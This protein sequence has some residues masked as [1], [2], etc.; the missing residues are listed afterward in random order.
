MAEEY[1][2]VERAPTVAEYNSVSHSAGLSIK[3]ERAAKW[4]VD[5][6]LYAVCVEHEGVAIGIGRV[7]GDGGLSFDIIDVAVA[8]A[9]RGKGVRKMIIDALMRYVDAHARPSSVIS[10]M[11]DRGIASFYEKYGFNARDPDM[12]GM[13]IRK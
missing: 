3:E 12:P 8:K 10:S 6:S 7:I 5:H 1:V 4:G 13:I 2:V 11:A 9:H